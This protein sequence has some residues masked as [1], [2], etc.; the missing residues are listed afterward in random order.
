METKQYREELRRAGRAAVI[1]VAATA[2]MTLLMAVGLF[3]HGPVAF[4]PFPIEF[5]WRLLPTWSS[6]SLAVLTTLLHF[7]Y[8]AAAGAAFS[9]LARPMSVGRGMAFGLA[10]WIVMQVFFVPAFYGWIEF[11]LARGEPYSALF[12]LL[13]HMV[14]GGVLG[15][16]GGRDERYHHAA[17]DALDRLVTA[18]RIS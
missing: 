14:Y 6:L 8:G 5:T 13:L 17:F 1:G 7:A 2:A 3:W 12:A 11:G 15:A 16:L 9:F 18:K 4:R 10:L